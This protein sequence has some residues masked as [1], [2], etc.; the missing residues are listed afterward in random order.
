MAKERKTL[1]P[2][3]VS[4][5]IGPPS[6]K[7]PRKL[8]P[9]PPPAP[10][11]RWTEGVI[12]EMLKGPFPDGAYVRIPQVR[13]GTGYVSRTRTCDAL[14]VS[15]WPSRGLWFAGIEIKVDPADWKRELKAPE[16]SD[17]I[18]RW[19]N[20][21]YVACPTGIVPI[22]ELPP[23]WGLIECDARGC[24]ITKPAPKLTPKPADAAFVC[25]VLRAATESMVPRSLVETM[26]EEKA[27]AKVAWSV[28]E[29]E[30]LR[31]DVAEFEKASG[32]SLR[33]RWEYGDASEAIK[34]IRR[35]RASGPRNMAEYMKDQAQ[36]LV[37]A[38][39]EVLAICDEVLADPKAAKNIGPS[40]VDALSGDA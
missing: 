14:I 24:K 7:K 23:T 22:G 4:E 32:I 12:F 2:V 11:T 5:I 40:S 19:C 13:N 3:S 18:Q 26:A 15:C 9:L 25:S 21:W 29:L 1:H 39:C 16:K 10:H 38:G 6:P 20:Y 31:E 27:E 35:S 33:N 28:R 17:A 37:K 30:K 34:L 36:R 8:G